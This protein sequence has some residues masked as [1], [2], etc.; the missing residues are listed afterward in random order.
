MNKPFWD[1]DENISV[2][3]IH[4]KM[5]ETLRI[6]FGITD[7]VLLFKFVFNAKVSW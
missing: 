5:T 7:P 2:H 1:K 4:I 6:R 3:L